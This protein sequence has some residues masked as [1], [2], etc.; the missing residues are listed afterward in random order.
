MDKLFKT[1]KKPPVVWGKHEGA[2]LYIKSSYA[3]NTRIRKNRQD[4]LSGLKT[5]KPDVH[6]SKVSQII[7]TTNFRVE[8]RSEQEKT[9]IDQKRRIR[10]LRSRQ[11]NLEWDLKKD[12]KKAVMDA[13]KKSE[14]EE[15]DYKIKQGILTAKFKKLQREEMKRSDVDLRLENKR[16]PSFRKS[17][18]PSVLHSS[19]GFRQSISD[20]RSKNLSPENFH[21]TF[22][23]LDKKRKELESSVSFLGNY[24]SGNKN[25]SSNV[26]SRKTSVSSQQLKQI[27]KNPSSKID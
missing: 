27:A 11:Q 20:L 13:K 7:N 14:K 18:K 2:P 22:S 1:L 15:L 26:H 19:V 23:K 10:E 21:F 9:I 16:D 6:T 3:S 17:A 5:Q 8:P 12:A 4:L 25:L 24:F